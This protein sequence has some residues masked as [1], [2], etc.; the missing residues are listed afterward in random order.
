MCFALAKKMRHFLA[1]IPITV[2]LLVS[3]CGFVHDEHIVGP[4]RLIAVDIDEQMSISYD[5]GN[6]SA[7]GRINETVFAYGYNERY[8]VAK[9][10]PNGDKSIT[11]YYYLDMTK[12]SMYADLSASVTGPLSQTEFEA[13]SVRLSLPNFTRTIKH[14]E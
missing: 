1:V 2:A 4:Y 6:G 9:Q 12:D 10:Y 5:L 3:G 7:A 13:A 8:I 14:L 11:N